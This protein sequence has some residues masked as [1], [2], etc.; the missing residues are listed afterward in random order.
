MAEILHRRYPD[1]QFNVQL[2]PNFSGTATTNGII[3]QHRELGSPQPIRDAAVYILHAD[4]P[5][6]TLSPSPDSHH[7]RLLAELRVLFTILQA[8]PTAVLI[9]VARG[10]PEQG[11]VDPSIELL[12]RVHDLALLELSNGREMDIGE[13]VGILNGVGDSKGRLVAASKVRVRN[14]AAVVFGVRYRGYEERAE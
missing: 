6:P 5:P 14:G 3:T 11:S 7:A 13:V 2:D 12:G 10:L 8:N 9:L 4:L 1:L